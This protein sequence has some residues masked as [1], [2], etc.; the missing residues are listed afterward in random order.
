MPSGRVGEYA[1]H[2]VVPVGALACNSGAW[3]GFWHT[4]TCNRVGRGPET[5]IRR[6]VQ[7]RCVRIVFPTDWL[8][9]TRRVLKQVHQ[10]VV[11]VAGVTV[12]VPVGLASAGVNFCDLRIGGGASVRGFRTGSILRREPLP[13]LV[14]VTVVKDWRRGPG[15]QKLMRGETR[16]LIRLKHVIGIAILFSDLKIWVYVLRFNVR[17]FRIAHGAAV[18]GQTG[19]SAQPSSLL[20][21]KSWALLAVY[22]VTPSLVAVLYFWVASVR[23]RGNPEGNPVISSTGEPYI[24]SAFRVH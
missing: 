23:F 20:E 13:V 19:K 12:A 5:R 21:A 7:G 2:V 9:G 15:E 22:S 18:V 10:G 6:T 4:D 16:S 8:Y 24:N 11:A 17:V 3:D 14:A 1:L